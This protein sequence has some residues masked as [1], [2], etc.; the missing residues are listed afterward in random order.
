MEAVFSPAFILTGIG[1]VSHIPATGKKRN[2][3][4]SAI[5][6][7]E[8]SSYPTGNHQKQQLSQRKPSETTFYSR[9]KNSTD[10]SWHPETFF[11]P[12][13]N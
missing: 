13:S 11:S 2:I 4:V 8:T 7:T 1:D 3:A 10:L 9:H 5:I 12:M 6:I